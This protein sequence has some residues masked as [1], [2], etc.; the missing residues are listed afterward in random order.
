MPYED[1]SL[2]TLQWTFPRRCNAWENMTCTLLGNPLTK[3]SHYNTSCTYGETFSNTVWKGK[4]NAH[5]IW[6][7]NLCN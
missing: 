2:V 1:A 5:E 7:N 3:S 6:H 4:K